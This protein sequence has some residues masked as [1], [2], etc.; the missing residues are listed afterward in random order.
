MHVIPA[1][2]RHRRGGRRPAPWH[3]LQDVKKYPVMNGTGIGGLLVC[4]TLGAA[5]NT[6]CDANTTQVATPTTHALRRQHHT[7]CD[8][9]TTQ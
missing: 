3:E 8:A 7:S 1:L 6:S 4:K 5:R 9:N 2:Q